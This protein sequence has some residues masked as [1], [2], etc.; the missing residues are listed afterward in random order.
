MKFLGVITLIAG[1][2]LTLVVC[3]HDFRRMRIAVRM[4]QAAPSLLPPE[5]HALA[6]LLSGLARIS[7]RQRKKDHTLSIERRDPKSEALSEQFQ[8]RVGCSVRR[9]PFFSDVRSGNSVCGPLQ[10]LGPLPRSGELASRSPLHG[11]KCGLRTTI[12]W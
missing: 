1:I 9:L 4:P 10:R 11:E 12:I 2:G 3:L 7:N 6:A 8:W 5:T